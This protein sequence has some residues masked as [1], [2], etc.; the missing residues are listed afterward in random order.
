[1]LVKIV[2]KKKK[3]KRIVR[4]IEGRKGEFQGG[5]Q[6]RPETSVRFAGAF[7]FRGDALVADT[8]LSARKGRKGRSDDGLES[9]S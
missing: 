6:V 8:R 7:C 3:K 2:I 1:M 9:N 4:T 5:F